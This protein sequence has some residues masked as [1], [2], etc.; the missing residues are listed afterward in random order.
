MMELSLR[1]KQVAGMVEPCKTVADIGCDH[2][3]ISIYLIQQGI[4]AK[5]LAMDVRK[6]PLSRAKQHISRNHLEDRIQCRLSDG[7][8]QLQYGEADTILISGMGGP[9]MIEILKRGASKLKGTETLVLQPQS[10][11]PSVRRY[12]HKIGYG[13]REEQ[14][15]LEDG[16]YYVV[17]KAKNKEDAPWNNVEYQYGRCLLQ[18][19]SSVLWHFLKRE[20]QQMNQLMKQLNVQQTEKAQERVQELRRQQAWNQEA[21]GYYEA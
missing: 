7:L 18:Q 11:I 21:Q 4:A 14:M 15:L 2:G 8:E 19:R 20:E 10:D 3:Y 17:I 1:M 16:K 12:L 13:I 5:A 9:L 6:G